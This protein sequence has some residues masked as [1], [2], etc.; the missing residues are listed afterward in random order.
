MT[1]SQELPDEVGTRQSA[2]VAPQVHGH[3]KLDWRGSIRSTRPD[4]MRASTVIPL[5]AGIARW[6]GNLGTCPVCESRT[7][8]LRTGPWDRDQYRCIRCRSIPRFRAMALVLQREAPGWRD[9]NIHESSPDGAFSRKLSI[10]A[11]RYTYSQYFPGFPSGSLVDGVRCEDLRSMS[12]EDE[13]FDIFITQD[14]LEH[15]PDPDRAFTEIHRVLRPG[16]IHVF[17]V[18]CGDRPTRERARLLPDGAME[19][20]LPP[21]FHGNPVD[22]NGSLVVTDWGPDLLERIEAV[23]G[24]RTERSVFNDRRLGLLGEFLDVFVTRKPF[25]DS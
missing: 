25:R 21:E 12:F 19:H 16:G 9:A 15:V 14:V 7:L 13:S 22:P 11:G 10:D 8:F 23:T 2:C 24:C 6:G 20:L 17:T 4:D 18:P 1:M 3:P 5:L